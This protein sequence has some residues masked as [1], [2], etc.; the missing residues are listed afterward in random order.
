MKSSEI[1]V[2]K[3]ISKYYKNDLIFKNVN[4]SIKKGEV[5]S[6]I[7]RSGCGKSTLLKCINRLEDIAEGEIE[8]NG[9]N[10]IHIDVT[11]LRQK[12]G[13]VFQDYNLFEHLTVMENLTIGLTKIKGYSLTKSKELATEILKKIDLLEKKDKYP[14][15]LSGGQ[16][17]RVSIARTLLMKP[18]II[19]LDEPTSALDSEMKESVLLLINELVKEDMT[20]IIVSHEDDFVKKVSDKIYKLTK[21]GLTLVEE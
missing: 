6:I 3:D 15:E 12:I 2:L 18:D 11:E 14:D 7:G 13:I 21:N 5:V 9:I 1:L 8:L 17:Q 4:L 16:K 19:L 10:T 20:L